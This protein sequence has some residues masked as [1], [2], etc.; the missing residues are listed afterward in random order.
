MIYKSGQIEHQFQLIPVVLDY[1]I[2]MRFSFFPI[3]LH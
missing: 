1:A 2:L 3:E